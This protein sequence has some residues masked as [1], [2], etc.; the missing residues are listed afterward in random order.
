[1]YWDSIERP[2]LINEIQR[3]NAPKFTG[4]NIKILNNNNIF[5]YVNKSSLPKNFDNLIVQHK[6]DWFRLY[7][8]N[9]YGGCWIDMAIIINNKDAFND[10]W[11][12][13]NNIKSMLTGFIKTALTK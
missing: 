13:S 6:A 2:E 3:Y 11:Y 8:L 12:K 7:L 5:D 1:M 9:H 4:W 10:I